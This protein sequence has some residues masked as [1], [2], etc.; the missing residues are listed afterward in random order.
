MDT[1]P[2]EPPRPKRSPGKWIVLLVVWG[3]GLLVWVLYVIVIGYVAFKFL[4]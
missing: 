1:V 4:L 2:P 3:V